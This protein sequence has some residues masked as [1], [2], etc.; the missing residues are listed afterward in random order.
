MAAVSIHSDFGAQK[1][2]KSVTV[3]TI[4]QSICQEVM[5]PDAMILIV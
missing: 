1:S 4:S 3:S 2:I 5:R